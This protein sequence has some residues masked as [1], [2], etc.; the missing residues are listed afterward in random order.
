MNRDRFSHRQAAVIDAVPVG[1]G[2][3]GALRHHDTVADHNLT[4]GADADTGTEKAIFPDHHSSPA[5]QCG[6]DSQPDP[7]VRRCDDMGAGADGNGSSENLDIPG[8]HEGAS[9]T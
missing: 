3:K 2:N 9:F 7:L 1:I 6:P 8:L 4:A 5:L